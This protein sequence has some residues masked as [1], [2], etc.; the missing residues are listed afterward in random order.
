MTH[1][2]E[3]RIKIT[4]AV[5]KGNTYIIWTLGNGPKVYLYMLADLENLWMSY[6]FVYLIKV[7]QKPNNTIQ[8]RHV[9]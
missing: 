3:V 6:L 8:N 2:C 5:E 4:Y 1:N 7:W 9:L